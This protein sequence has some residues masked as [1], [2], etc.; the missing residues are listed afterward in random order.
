[1]EM[2][3][4]E[5]WWFVQDEQDKQPFFILKNTLNGKES[6]VPFDPEEESAY[7]FTERAIKSKPRSKHYAE[8][9]QLANEELSVHFDWKPY[10]RYRSTVR[11]NK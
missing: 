3:E 10:G 6:F 9:R 5:S 11:I 4:I 8:L 7:S 2:I 1:M